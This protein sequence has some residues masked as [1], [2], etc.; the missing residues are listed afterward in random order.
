MSV[1]SDISVSPHCVHATHVSHACR[2]VRRSANCTM[3]NDALMNFLPSNKI[4]ILSS[5]FLVEIC[6]CVG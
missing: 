6:E 1:H 5:K 3:T 2:L 4:R